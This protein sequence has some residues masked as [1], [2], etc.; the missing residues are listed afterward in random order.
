MATIVSEAQKPMS[1]R[2]CAGRRLRPLERRRRA[3]GHTVGEGD[4][5]R[6][7]P[8]RGDRLLHEQARLLA[9]GGPALRGERWVEVAPPGRGAALALVPPRGAAPV[10]LPRPRREPADDRRRA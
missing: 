6:V 7:R 2:R 10:L 1:F 4:G 9:G 5:P 3:T 8:G